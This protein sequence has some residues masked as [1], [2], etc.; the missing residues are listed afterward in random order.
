MPRRRQKSYSKTAS[1]R[2]DTT[3]VD[4]QEVYPGIGHERKRDPAQVGAPTAAPITMSGRSL[5]GQGELLLGLEAIT[6]W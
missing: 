1:V 5:A 3:R 6:V 4:R 2:S